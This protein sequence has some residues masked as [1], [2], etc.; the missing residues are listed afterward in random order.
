[1]LREIWNGLD[2]S[3][4]ADIL[5][6]IIPALICIT[7]HELCHGLIAY[8][9]G[10]TTA[11]DRG[12]LSLNPLKHIDIVGL[13]MLIVFRFGWAKPVPV[14]MSRFKNP[15]WGMAVT[16]IAGPLSNLVL[17]ALALFLFGLLYV[18]LAVSDMGGRVLDTLYYTGYLSTALAV[19]NLIPI[20]P[21]DG[22]K[23]LF[24]FMSESSYD[25][26]MRYERFGILLLIALVNFNVFS[27]PLGLAVTGVFNGLSVLADWGYKLSGLFI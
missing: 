20:P 6:R 3:V 17:T 26:L 1:M 19:F 10:D 11:K 2:W 8:L 15:R 12:R 16:A 22:S 24:A 7:F 5:M 27:A 13:M 9:L 14:D 21:L 4:W 25:R 18:P 23:V